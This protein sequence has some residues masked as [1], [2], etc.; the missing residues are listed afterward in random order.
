MSA[1]LAV[2]LISAFVA[3]CSAVIDVI[4]ALDQD[5]IRLPQKHLKRLGG[6]TPARR[7]EPASYDADVPSEPRHN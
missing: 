3:V 5:R 4:D 7:L 1:A 6:Q 2:A